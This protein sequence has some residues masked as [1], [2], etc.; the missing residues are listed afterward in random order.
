MDLFF[1]NLHNEVQKRIDA[2]VRRTKN[3]FYGTGLIES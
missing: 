3:P 2:A 1:K